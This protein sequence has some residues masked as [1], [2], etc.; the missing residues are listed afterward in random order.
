MLLAGIASSTVWTLVADRQDGVIIVDEIE[1]RKG[2]GYGYRP[3]F[4]GALHNGLEFERGERR[5]DWVELLL[6]DGRRAWVPETAVRL[7][8]R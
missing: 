8:P 4:Q 2:P 1:A 5:E 6:S 7:I 3:A